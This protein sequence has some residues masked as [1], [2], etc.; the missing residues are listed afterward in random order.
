MMQE[1]F[2]STRR[3]ALTTFQAL[4]IVKDLFISIQAGLW[5]RRW[6]TVTKST[7]GLNNKKVSFAL[8]EGTL[9][10]GSSLRTFPHGSLR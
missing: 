10:F 3:P 8:A 2:F 9:P 4:C 6:P 1:D 7:G 5:N